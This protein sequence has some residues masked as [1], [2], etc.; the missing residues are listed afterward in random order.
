MRVPD[1][2]DPLRAGMPKF[3]SPRPMPA[4]E[5]RSQLDSALSHA[6]IEDEEDAI[7]AK[8]LDGTVL[9]WN[10]GATRIFGYTAAEMIGGPIA[11]LFPEDRR[12][13]EAE[14]IAQLAHGKKISHFV[15]QRL[16][17]SGSL[18]DVSVT[19]SPVRDASGKI[20]GISKI[21]RDITEAYQR[22]S[23]PPSPPR[24]SSTVTTPS[25]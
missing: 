15:T 17:K 4:Q 24:S 3:E 8:S 18:I 12:N 13:E 6:I 11:R 22:T 2:K 19:L 25:S 16:R 1:N 21:A 14:L 5:P 23:C 20:V 9:T 7:V 10:S